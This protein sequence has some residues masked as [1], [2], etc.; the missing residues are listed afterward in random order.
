MTI[1]RPNDDILTS[2]TSDLWLLGST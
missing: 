1:I 2:G